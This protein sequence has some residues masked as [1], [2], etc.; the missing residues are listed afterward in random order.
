MCPVA[1]ME[2]KGI[3]SQGSVLVPLSD[4]PSRCAPRVHPLSGLSINTNHGG[5]L[6]CLSEF[7]S[8]INS[9]TLYTADEVLDINSFV[10]RPSFASIGTSIASYK[11]EKSI[12][13]R[14]SR[15]NALPRHK[16]AD[17]PHLRP[18]RGP[19]SSDVDGAPVLEVCQTFTP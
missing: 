4:L 1:P 8:M 16:Y 10:S 9:I 6:S 11:T 7:Y 2:W 3:F 13:S 5:K 17:T 14:K 18:P 12:N 15:Y 19:V